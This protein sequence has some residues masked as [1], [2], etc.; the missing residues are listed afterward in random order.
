VSGARL[1]R[2]SLPRSDP[3]NFLFP[4]FE[5]TDGHNWV[6]IMSAPITGKSRRGTGT[7]IGVALFTLERRAPPIL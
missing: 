3:E 7:M 2:F 1:I 5:P 6:W 4:N